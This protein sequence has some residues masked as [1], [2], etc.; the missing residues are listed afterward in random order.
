MFSVLVFDACTIGSTR[1]RAFRS[2]NRTRAVSAGNRGLRSSIPSS[3]S[4]GFTPRS[5]EPLLGRVPPRA[6]RCG[7]P[8]TP[9]RS[10]CGAVRLAANPQKKRRPRAARVALHQALGQECLVAP[11]KPQGHVPPN[12]SPGGRPPGRFDQLGVLLHQNGRNDG[13]RV[14]PLVEQLVEDPPVRVLGGEGRPEHLDPHRRDLRNDRRVV[15]EPPAPVQVE[16]PELRRQ[17]A[18]LVL[19]G[20]R[21]EGRQEAD[22]REAGAQP[23][24]RA[25]V[26]DDAVAGLPE[27][28][29]HPPVGTDLRAQGRVPFRADPRED[30]RKKVAVL[31]DDAREFLLSGAALVG[32]AV[33]VVVASPAVSPRHDFRKGKGFPRGPFV[34]ARRLGLADASRRSPGRTKSWGVDATGYSGC[35]VSHQSCGKDRAP[36]RVFSHP[37]A[38]S[39]V[40]TEARWPASSGSDPAGRPNAGR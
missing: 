36:S 26:G 31:V 25:C 15:A 33:V 24:Q 1:K 27:A 34:H 5:E 9:R 13:P 29:V 12:F 11:P 10:D 19:V 23:G 4:C 14:G 35:I 40:S 8:P 37:A 30:V 28:G 7:L 17:D 3:R 20:P 22:P 16:V 21:Q 6:S 39:A 18:R 38:A 2:T 32:V